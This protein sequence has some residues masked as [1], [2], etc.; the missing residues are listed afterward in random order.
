M[1]ATAEEQD[2]QRKL[3]YSAALPVSK[4]GDKVQIYV[5]LRP[6][7]GEVDHETFRVL[8]DTCL[9]AHPPK[10]SRVTE[11]VS[12]FHF[13]QVFRPETTQRDLFDQTT[14]AIVDEALEGKN[15]LVFAYGVTN[16]GKTYTILGTPE[17]PGI[18]PETLLTLFKKADKFRITASYLEIYNEKVFDLLTNCQRRIFL[19]LLEKDGRVYVKD[20][21]ERPIKSFEEAKMLLECGQK[22]R[23][24]GETKCN[25][26]SS[27]S[28]C[29]F[30]LQLY[31]NEHPTTL[32]SKI[33]IVDLAGCER[34][35]KTGA[36]GLRLQEA[37]KINGSLMNL[38]RCLETLRFN[39][40]HPKSERP[41]PFRSSKLTRLFQAS[42][43]CKQAGRIIMIVT[44]N[45]STDEFDETLRTLQ[46]SAIAKEVVTAPS[47][48]LLSRR[49][50]Q[51]KTEYG[52]DGHKKRK[53]PSM[54]SKDGA[55]RTKTEAT[56]L[57][58][59]KERG[60]IRSRTSIQRIPVPASTRESSGKEVESA[61]TTTTLN[62]RAKARAS[63]AVVRPVSK[64]RITEHDIQILRDEIDQLKDE[65]LTK[66][67]EYVQQ[68]MQ[69]RRELAHEL[70][71]Q[72]DSMKASY[73][74]KLADVRAELK[75][76]LDTTQKVTQGT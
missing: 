38:N 69:L 57:P 25:T 16:S 50:V 5:R 27:R 3:S 66:D 49:P 74:V 45:P 23:Q 64:K 4:P 68:E 59:I 12:T 33:S 48:T 21:E 26:D 30:S 72:L 28:H 56:Y 62:A 42:F 55:S 20:L 31:H 47:K 58:M 41:V 61:P 43:V 14:Y 8:S 13:S 53:R 46:Y 40:L 24:V 70:N 65:L 2:I 52:T 34:G 67:A 18:L 54:P 37:S 6:P 36:S 71:K 76:S 63:L 44:V 10:T 35:A 75:A 7:T 17:H 22:N 73:E 51:V 15:G 19:H 39:Q 32:F 1:S 9:V 11:S 60:S 29:V